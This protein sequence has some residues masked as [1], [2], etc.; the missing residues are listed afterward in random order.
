[1]SLTAVYCFDHI[2]VFFRFGVFFLYSLYFMFILLSPTKSKATR[3]FCL[4]IHSFVRS[5]TQNVIHGLGRNFHGK[6]MLILLRTDKN[7]W[8][9][10]S[11]EKGPSMGEISRQFDPGWR[12]SRATAF[13]VMS[14]QAKAFKGQAHPYLQEGRDTVPTNFSYPRSPLS[15]CCSYKIWHGEVTWTDE[16]L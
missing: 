4:F 11:P 15:S 12:C 14:G 9:I 8:T 5:V 6:F 16:E 7:F 10:Y 2:A 3:S 13:S 1:M